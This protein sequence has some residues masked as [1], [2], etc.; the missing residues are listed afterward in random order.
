MNGLGTLSNG[1]SL[2]KAAGGPNWSGPGTV[3]GHHR[4]LPVAAHAGMAQPPS[5]SLHRAPCLAPLSAAE[6][7]R[8]VASVSSGFHHCPASSPAFRPH[9]AADDRLQDAS[10]LT[11]A[12]RVATARS[13]ASS[14][15]SSIPA[16]VAA[17]VQAAVEVLGP[18][19][20]RV[21]ASIQVTAPLISVW[22]VLTDY[23]RLANYVP[24]LAKNEVLELREGGARLLQVG[25]SWVIP[26]PCHL[27]ADSASSQD[28]R[29]GRFGRRA[30]PKRPF[31]G[32]HGQPTWRFSVPF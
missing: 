23:Y 9:A 24:S 27:Q 20:R 15:S 32:Y 10:L 4:S 14:S 22:S 2:S 31:S 6:T 11:S 30:A 25:R 21:S 19:S 1:D 8:S 17:A 28:A 18:N 13:A 29:R 7:P 12:S 16:P 5:T 3:L 26:T